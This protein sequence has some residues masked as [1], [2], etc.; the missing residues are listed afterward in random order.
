MLEEL[1][2]AEESVYA[3][4]GE[5]A[6]SVAASVRSVGAASVV[7]S[8]I[9]SPTPVVERQSHLLLLDMR[10]V[11]EYERWHVRGALSFPV[12][13]LKHATHSLPNEVYYYRGARDGD[14]MIV[15]YDEDGRTAVELGNT[16]VQK[17][18]DNLYVVHG[19]LQ[20]FAPRFPHLLEG[21]VPELPPPSTPVQPLS[22]LGTS[23]YR[24]SNRPPSTAASGRTT[25]TVDTRLSG[26]QRGTPSSSR[27]PSTPGSRIWK[28]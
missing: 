2:R 25:R 22:A 13:Q 26:S 6:V 28:H 23:G 18:I 14:K 27:G 15:V 1:L 5:D 20:Q 3:L 7:H 21:D 24:T 16:L 9:A 11:E 17:G 10:P 12:S 8:E 19:G 4:G